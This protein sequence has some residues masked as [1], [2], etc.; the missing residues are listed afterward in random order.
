[1]LGRE[2]AV[3]INQELQPGMHQI[4][5]SSSDYDLFFGGAQFVIIDPKTGRYFG[6]ADRRRGGVAL[7]Y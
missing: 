7:G 5:F 2:I 1:M 6:S 3:L 4:S